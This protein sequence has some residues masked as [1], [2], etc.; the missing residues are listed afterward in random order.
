MRKAQ[1]GRVKHS[2]KKMIRLISKFVG[3]SFCFP[4]V[5]TFFFNFLLIKRRTPIVIN[6][7]S[8]EMRIWF[9]LMGTIGLGSCPSDWFFLSHHGGVREEQAGYF[10]F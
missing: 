6:E 10:L 4:D 1:A 7:V 2:S 8:I 5:R 9:I 3:M